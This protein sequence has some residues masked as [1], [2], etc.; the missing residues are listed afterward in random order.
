MARSITLKLLN[1]KYSGDSIG[2]DIRVEIEILNKLSRI[3]KRIK[4]GT[5][6]KINK[7]I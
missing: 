7:E 1:I 2:D 3:D 5:T 4:S 6:A